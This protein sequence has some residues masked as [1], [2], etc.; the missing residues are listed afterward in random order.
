MA[1]RARRGQGPGMR[2]SLRDAHL[3][4]SAEACQLPAFRR[5]SA[6]C[7]SG[8]E[9]PKSRGPDRRSSAGRKDGTQRH[10][11]DAEPLHNPRTIRQR[12][13][14]NTSE[15]QSLMRISSAVFCLKKKKTNTPN[16]THRN[17]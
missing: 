3:A 11:S 16:K 8:A 12:S 17:T 2:I 4:R 1:A 7:G 5:R 15:L 10:Y 14:E 9:Q 6:R 13:E